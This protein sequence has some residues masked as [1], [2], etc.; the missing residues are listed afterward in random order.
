[1]EANDDMASMSPTERLFWAKVNKTET[2]WLWAGAR[3]PAGYGHFRRS[4]TT[5]NAHRFAYELLVGPVEKG[6]Q[7]DH[8]CRVRNCVR[9][10]H[11]EAV[12]P[13]I[14]TRR[15]MAGQWKKLAA[16][17][18]KRDSRTGRFIRA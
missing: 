17:H 5:Y 8:L 3:N 6:L 1:M 7:I 15:G 10:S 2:C 14:N 12:T 18:G 4:G 9:P 11:M 13:L 16:H